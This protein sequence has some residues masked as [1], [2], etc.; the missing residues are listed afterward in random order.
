MGTYYETGRR[1]N[2]T[3]ENV[4]IVGTTS[5]RGGTTD[6]AVKLVGA[7]GPQTSTV[8]HIPLDHVGVKVVPV[9]PPHWPPQ[10][11]DVWKGDDL[12]WF[13]LPIVD[14]EEGDVVGVRLV[15]GTD[16]CPHGVYGGNPYCYEDAAVLLAHAQNLTLFVRD[17]QPVRQPERLPDPWNDEP[18]F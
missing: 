11:N 13:A 15:S 3:L 14:H 12:T 1:Y 16:R 2:V 7:N 17:G 5:E 8:L 10:V 4:V 6:I 18:P 9:P